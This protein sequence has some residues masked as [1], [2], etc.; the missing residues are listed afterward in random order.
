MPKDIRI[1]LAQRLRDLRKNAGLS[2]SELAKRSRVSR[3]HIRDLELPY[4]QK[5]SHYCD[6]R[7]ACPRTQ[8]SPLEASSVQRLALPNQKKARARRPDQVLHDLLDFSPRQSNL[9]ILRV[10]LGLT[11]YTVY[12]YLTDSKI[13]MTCIVCGDTHRFLAPLS[14]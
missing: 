9:F 8:D 1:R 4:P 11:G 2:T 3:Q 13:V 14:G 6:P 10:R 7:K 12:S 5:K